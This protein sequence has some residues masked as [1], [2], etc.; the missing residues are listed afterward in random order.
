[1]NYEDVLKSVSIEYKKILRDNLV[2]IYVHGSIAL[3][4]FNWDKSDI[5][6]IVVVNK[7]LTEEIKLKF[8]DFTIELNKQAPPKGLEMSVVLKEYCTNFIY[9]TPYELHFSNMHLDWYNSDSKDYCKKMSGFDKDLAAHF[10]IIKNSGVVL[11]G[12]TINEV[13]AEIPR[14]D[15]LDSIKND[16]SDA[17]S[18]VYYNP[19]YILLNLC[20]V[21][22][23]VRDNLILSKEK[24]GEWGLYNLDKCYHKIINEALYSY[25][26]NEIM[27]VDEE[28]AKEFSDY[29]LKNIN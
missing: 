21:L 12:L 23:Y 29:M 1:M 18:E 4:C 8:M 13:F 14:E 22:A 24:G 10:T 20:R 19:V 17:K 28:E 7:P 15:Y 26:T 11:Y 25:K 5:D 27:K 6:Y 9:P 3:G 16:I 2:G